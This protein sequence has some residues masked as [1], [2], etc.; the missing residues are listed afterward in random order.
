MTTVDEGADAV[1][2]LITKEGIENGAYYS[3]LRPA[4]A[5]AQAYDKEARERLWELSRKLTSRTE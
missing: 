4:R 2:Q 3:G 5:Q 1:M